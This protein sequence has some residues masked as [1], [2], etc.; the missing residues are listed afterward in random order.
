MHSHSS[1]AGNYAGA[2][3]TPHTRGAS[4]GNSLDTESSSVSLKWS[5]AHQD[6][7]TKNEKRGRAERNVAALQAAQGNAPTNAQRVQR[8]SKEGRRK[9]Q[10]AGT[11]RRENRNMRLAIAKK[12]MAEDA[13]DEAHRAQRAARIEQEA[14][15]Q[16]NANTQKDAAQ[17][18][19][20][21]NRTAGR[22]QGT[23]TADTHSSERERS[24][25]QQLPATSTRR[26]SESCRVSCGARTAA[27]HD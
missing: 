27:R 1:T 4:S 19:Q 7:G 24:A 6:A 25:R 26:S 21:R 2:A 15:T 16:E 22:T 12:V 14:R 17:A 18:A 5:D 10:N 13:S 11:L 9:H 8:S 23:S 20:Q 3:E